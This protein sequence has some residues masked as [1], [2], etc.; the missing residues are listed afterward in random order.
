MQDSP[1]INTS[2]HHKV[3]K[4]LTDSLYPNLLTTIPHLAVVASILVYKLSGHVSRAALLS[5]LTVFLAFTACQAGLVIWYNKTRDQDGSTPLQFKLLLADVALIGIMWGTAGV[6]FMPQDTIGQSYLIL[7]IAFVAAGG[8]IYLSGSWLAS[9]VYATGVLFPL[10]VTLVFS[11]ISKNHHEVYF[12][13]AVGL[14]CYWSFLLVVS[15][16]ASKIISENFT[17]GF[18]NK[19]LRA[20]K[21]ELEKLNL[22]SRMEKE[23]HLTPEYNA[24]MDKTLSHEILHAD[25]LTGADTAEVLAI[26]FTQA[27]AF[28]RRHQ[29]SLAILCIDINDFND[30][31]SKL[32][33]DFGNLLLKTV[34][35]RLQYCKRETDILAR[36]GDGKFVLVV[37][38]V[39]LGSEIMTVVNKILKIFAEKTIIN[40]GTV[41]INAGIGISVFPKDGEE[42]PGLIGNAEKALGHLYS[43]NGVG[44]FRIYDGELMG[45][46]ARVVEL[47][48]LP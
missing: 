12:N 9:S 24:E 10:L 29:Q 44:G 3:K 35:V 32:G 43:E 6:L 2:L 40:E 45:V 27:R 31:N 14:V 28:A 48:P 15:Y 41:E 4:E 16:Y 7:I 19:S 25:A 23:K 20:D 36:L 21:E 47:P 33:E 38:E 11:L 8:P 39:L 18:V 30:V 46:E 1:E 34:A 5:W 17:H 42:L 13:L 26:R 37:S 22:I